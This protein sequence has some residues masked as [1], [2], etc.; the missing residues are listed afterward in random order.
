[1]NIPPY[2]LNYN[3]ECNL[4]DGNNGT[5]FLKVSKELSLDPEAF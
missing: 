4:S 1:M 2:N 5:E 3:I